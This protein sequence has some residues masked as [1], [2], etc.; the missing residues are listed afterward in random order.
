[1]ILAT[2]QAPDLAHKSQSAYSCSALLAACLCCLSALANAQIATID[3][4]AQRDFV[5]QDGVYPTI[6]ESIL[7]FVVTVSNPGVSTINDLEFTVAISAGASV[8]N[9]DS[10]CIVSEEPLVLLTCNI[11]ELKANRS[12]IIDFY[13]DGPNSLDV[14]EGFSVSIE[15]SDATVL[16][17]DAVEATL[18]DGDREIRGANLSVHLVRNIDL[19]INQNSVP[20][21]DEAI[22]NLPAST[23]VDELLARE[24]VVDVLFIHSPAASDY[25]G[26]KLKDRADQIISIA[27]Q[28]FRE[29]DVAIKFNGVGLEEISY[30]A[31]DTNILNTFEAL[32]GR[33][34]PA[35]DEIENLIT[36]SGGDIVV[37]MH[38]VDTNTAAEC[39]W[40]S[41]NAVGRQGD[42]QTIYH[43]GRLVSAINFGPDCIGTI[44]LAPVFASNMGIARE[45]Q[46]SPDG[47][48]FS[49]SAGYGI[50]DAFLTLGAAIGTSSLG[51]AFPIGRFSNPESF[52]LGIACGVDRNDTANGADAVYSMNKTRHLVSA[53]SPTVFHIEPSA[54][55]DKISLLANV[56]DLEVVQTTVETDALI[57]EFTE[58]DVRVTNRSSVTLSN[59]DLQFAHV[60]AGLIVEE[61]HNYETSSSLCT[62]LGSRLSTTELV[63]GDAIQKTGTLTCTIE[64]IAPGESLSFDYRVQIDSTPPLLNNEAYYHEVV[65]VNG[66]PQ[67]ESL[68]CIPVFPTFVEANAGSSVCNA[69]QGITLG[70]GPQSLANLDQVA[71]VTGRQLS[72][73]FIRLDDGSLVSAEFQITFFG[74]VRFELLSYQELD[75]S[76]VPVVEASLTSVGVLSL[77]NL[78]VGGINYD[79]EAALEPNSNPVRF[80]SLNIAALSSSP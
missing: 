23:P 66:A 64:S 52:C 15:S 10:E 9:V 59:I 27:N 71:T 80:G 77:P 62:I 11:D 61:E 47:G 6:G 79:I 46:R 18:A 37:M 38:V 3:L 4:S 69:V 21:L 20:D 39:G 25:L 55:E 36:L 29:N 1:M 2:P 76:I 53:L 56:Y 72:V 54:I 67:L 78:L 33:T 68:V 60:N 58:I 31:T 57:N 42:F 51:S 16:E 50:T 30:T 74:E 43:Q 12:K 22:M 19:D 45:R 13:V 35:F 48:T 63:V 8:G 41:L 49:Y 70:F 24:A 17:P 14:G 44:D 40:T 65:E 75:S 73:P 34:D 28:V 7:P 32:Q 26:R 5:Y